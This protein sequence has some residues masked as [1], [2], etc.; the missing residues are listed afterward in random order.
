MPIPMGI[1]VFNKHVINR[2]F[3]LFAGWMRPFAIVHHRGRSTGRSYRT[4]IMAFPTESGFVFA[5]TYGR[6]VDW[7]KNLMSSDGGFLEYGGGEIP[8]CGARFGKIGDVR[9]VFPFWVRLPL[10]IISIEECVLVEASE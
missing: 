9:E 6:D 1:A 8:L 5:L 7:V 3:L 2:F 10:S 4:P